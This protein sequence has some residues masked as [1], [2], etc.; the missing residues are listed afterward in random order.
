[1]LVRGEKL[2][3]GDRTLEGRYSLH[4][5]PQALTY[6][7][8]RQAR[9]YVVS[10]LPSC[11]EATRFLLTILAPPWEFP[12]KVRKKQGQPW[13]HPGHRSKVKGKLESILLPSLLQVLLC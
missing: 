3:A 10:P 7:A 2:G 13:D 8:H 9:L 11:P 4:V 5:A 6:L 1:M 12:G